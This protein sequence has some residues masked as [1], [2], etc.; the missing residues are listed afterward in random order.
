MQV[1][2]MDKAHTSGQ[3]VESMSGAM[4]TTKSK[5]KEPII[6]PMDVKSHANGSM[7]SSTEK[8]RC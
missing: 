6:I 1:R 8:V 5:D 2:C 7:V 4:K 3:T